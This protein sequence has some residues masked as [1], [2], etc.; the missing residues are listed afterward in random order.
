MG[1]A[2]SAL[3]RAVTPVAAPTEIAATVCTLCGG[4]GGHVEEREDPTVCRG[5]VSEVWV[6][7]RCSAERSARAFIR[8]FAPDLLSA[9]DVAANDDLVKQLDL[10]WHLTASWADVAPHLK[11]A[12]I[13]RRSKAPGWR[14]RIYRDSELAA[15]AHADRI[16]RD[17]GARDV[18]TIDADANLMIIRVGF[19]TAVNAGTSS[20]IG[21]LISAR[22]GR[23]GR[24]LWILDSPTARFAPKSVKSWTP[25]VGNLLTGSGIPY[26]V[27]GA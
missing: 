17:L 24:A 10:S 6:E 21:D 18:E 27:W 25:D 1:D 26:A 13:A 2:L 11:A 3:W 7:C 4:A 15:L 19:A 20:A 22:T 23:P 12:L 5:Y 8:D 16:A 9:P 14:V